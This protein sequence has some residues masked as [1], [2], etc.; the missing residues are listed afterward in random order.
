MKK[1]ALLAIA[2]FMTYVSFA[3]SSL[4][5]GFKIGMNYSTFTG[6]D[7]K[8]S[9]AEQEEMEAMGMSDFKVTYK[10][11][12]HVG[13]FLNVALTDQFSLRPEVMYSI[14]GAKFSF[15]GPDFENIDWEE[16]MNDP[17]NY[18]LGT[19][20]Y[21]GSETLYY[22][23]VPV[24]L[25]Y[26]INRIALQAGPTASLFL[27]YK[28][29]FEGEEPEEEE[30][31]GDNDYRKLDLGYAAGVSYEL[32]NGIGFSLRY[33]GGLS[34]LDKHNNYKAKNSTFQF[35]LSYTIGNK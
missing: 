3:Q 20:K 17:E 9:M 33:N 34:N 28:S 14:K 11:D 5:Y 2:L 27:K 24:L 30:N 31:A 35:S 19:R 15:N 25:Q 13:A 21:E 23:D 18:Q 4:T 26:R 29:E 22:L 6:K 32:E 16:Y 10:P 8:P 1:L 7:A 12:L